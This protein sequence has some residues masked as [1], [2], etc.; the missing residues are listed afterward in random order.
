MQFKL[1]DNI[2][3]G[4]KEGVQQYFILLNFAFN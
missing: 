2:K 4:T 1:F 3:Y